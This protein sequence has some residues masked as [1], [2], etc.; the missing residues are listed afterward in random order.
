MIYCTSDLHGYPIDRFK[1]M[2]AHIGFGDADDLYILGDVIDRGND[3]VA[4]LRWIMAT[5]NIHLIR[6][7]HEAMM[8]ANEFLFDMITEDT[9]DRLTGDELWAYRHWM[10]NGGD[11]TLEALKILHRKSVEYIYEFLKDTPL[12]EAVTVGERDF[13]LVHSGLGGFDEDKRISD[14]TQG[15]LLWYRPQ[16]TTRFFDD[17]T[18]VFGHTPTF[19]YGD[20][21]AGKAIKTDT[22]INIDVGAAV[23]N[24]PMIL[25]L[26]DMKEFYF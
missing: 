10:D 8:L 13:L 18:V 2:L 24:A 5:P 12:Y 20:D 26:D 3:G 25:R 21:Y 1:Q 6:G 7:N 17:I 16:L 22:W 11:K 14:Y 23:G 19:A 15:D 9:I 4:L